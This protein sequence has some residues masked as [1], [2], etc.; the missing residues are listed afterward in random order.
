MNSLAKTLLNN[1][2]LRALTVPEEQREILSAQFGASAY[3]V[4][5]HKIKFAHFQSDFQGGRIPYWHVI[6]PSSK[7]YHSTLSMQGL[8]EWGVL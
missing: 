4:R 3:K 5:P 1:P 7:S 2:G 6:D 8:K